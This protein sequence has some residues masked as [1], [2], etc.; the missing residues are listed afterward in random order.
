MIGKIG[1]K[2]G[3]MEINTRKTFTKKRNLKLNPKS[4]NLKYKIGEIGT[5]NGESSIRSKRKKMMRKNENM[6]LN[7]NP[8]WKRK[9]QNKNNNTKWVIG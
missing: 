4:N 3:N 5:N 1:P 6:N 7:T 9:N 2:I 8:K